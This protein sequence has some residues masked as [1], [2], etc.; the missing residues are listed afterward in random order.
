MNSSAQKTL[1]ITKR[2]LSKKED[3]TPAAR[4]SYGV[5]ETLF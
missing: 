1:N 5:R 3:K 2:L 4:C